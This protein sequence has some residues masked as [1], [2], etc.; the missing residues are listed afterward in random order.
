[1]IARSAPASRFKNG[2][3]LVRRLARHE[4]HALEPV[5]AL[6]I[7]VAVADALGALGWV[8]VAEVGVP[9]VRGRHGIAATVTCD[10]RFDLRG[11]SRLARAVVALSHTRAPVSYRCGL[12]YAA[13][14]G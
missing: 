6:L 13:H 4:V 14:E 11:Y 7:T 5:C 2:E 3:R 9:V 8:A 1:M 10:E 12:A